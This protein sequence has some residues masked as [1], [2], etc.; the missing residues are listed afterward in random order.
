Q[1]TNKVHTHNGRVCPPSF[2][3][4]PSARVCGPT[5][6]ECVRGGKAVVGRRVIHSSQSLGGGRRISA[7]NASI[8]IYAPVGSAAPVLSAPPTNNTRRQINR[9]AAAS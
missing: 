9:A 1:T 3:V 4:R 6:W 2:A 7:N 5:R 8:I